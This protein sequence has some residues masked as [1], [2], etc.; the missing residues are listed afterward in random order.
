[1]SVFFGCVFESWEMANLYGQSKGSV[2]WVYVIEIRMLFGDS[3]GIYTGGKRKLIVEEVIKPHEVIWLW[4]LT[5]SHVDQECISPVRGWKKLPSHML[6][7]LPMADCAVD[8]MRVTGYYGHS[9]TKR[10]RRCENLDL[11]TANMLVFLLCYKKMKIA[12]FRDG[13]SH[14]SSCYVSDNFVVHRRVSSSSECS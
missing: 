9:W 10:L 8:R 1:M 11:L 3:L 2:D 13:H 7:I 14:G 4:K 12:E 6:G 5:C